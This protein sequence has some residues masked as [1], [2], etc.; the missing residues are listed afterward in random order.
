MPEEKSCA[1]SRPFGLRTVRRKLGLAPLLVVTEIERCWRFVLQQRLGTGFVDRSNWLR[2]AHFDCAN[3]WRRHRDGALDRLGRI[4]ARLVVAT[5]RRYRFFLKGGTDCLVRIVLGKQR[6]SLHYD[7]RDF[8]GV[9]RESRPRPLA[10]FKFLY[11][12]RAYGIAVHVAG[13]GRH[14]SFTRQFKIARAS[15]HYVATCTTHVFITLVGCEQ[16]RFGTDLDFADTWRNGEGPWRVTLARGVHDIDPH[17][18][19]Q[20]AAERAAVNSF[21]LVETGPDRAGDGR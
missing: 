21:R 4:E 17:R 15:L 16:T 5:G 6:W 2:A 1:G 9:N 18:Q 8:L 10:A 20:H 13:I 12:L 14:L 3:R 11:Q 7:R 19:R